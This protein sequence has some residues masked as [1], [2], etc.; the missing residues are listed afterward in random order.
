MTGFHLWQCRWTDLKIWKV[1]TTS[2]LPFL[3]EVLPQDRGTG[4][5]LH[6]NHQCA[7]SPAKMP[8]QNWGM[9]AKKPLH[10]CPG[11]SGQNGAGGGV[12]E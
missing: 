1:P 6:H 3:L 8:P 12:G 4:M 11:N 5:L 2:D 9:L 10:A 7:L